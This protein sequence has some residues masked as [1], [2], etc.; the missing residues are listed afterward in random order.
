MT[1]KNRPNNIREG[2]L[3]LA[4]FK[5]ATERGHAYSS[6]LTRNYKD[7]EGQWQETPHLREQDHLPASRLFSRGHDYIREEK[8]RD[9]QGQAQ[10]QDQ[11]QSQQRGPQEP[12]R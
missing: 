4:I 10:S 6:K 5:N 8:K 12:S 2:V 11:S 9:R 3:N 1:E 7:Q